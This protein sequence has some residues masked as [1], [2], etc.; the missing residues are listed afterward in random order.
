ML[1]PNVS[2]GKG[3]SREKGL[4]E[5]EQGERFG[6]E[7]AGRKAWAR[8]TGNC[9]TSPAVAHGR[10]LVRSGAINPTSVNYGILRSFHNL[11]QC[12]AFLMGR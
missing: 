4:G 11:P 9:H 8:T 2:G 5:R 12:L 3:E 1:I 10:R 6:R 7:G